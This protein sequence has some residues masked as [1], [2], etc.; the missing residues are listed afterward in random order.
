MFT[1]AGGRKTS[2]IHMCG[3]RAEVVLSIPSGWCDVGGSWNFG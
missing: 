3:H 2:R 1:G